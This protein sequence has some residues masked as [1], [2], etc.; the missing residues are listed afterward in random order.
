MKI[1]LSPDEKEK[2][3]RDHR[4]ERNARVCDR[5]KAVLLRSED[6]TCRQIAQALRIHEET[7]RTHLSEWLKDQKL[8]PSNGGSECRLSC[9]QV[10]ALILHLEQNIYTKVTDICAYVLKTWKVRYTISGMTKWLHSHQFRYKQPKAVPAKSDTVLQQ[11]FIEY[12]TLLKESLSDK[13]PIIFI[14]A[15]HPTMATKVTYGWI[16]KGKEQL[17]KQSASRTRENIIGSIELNSLK[18]MTTHPEKVNAETTIEFL[19]KLKTIYPDVSVL[20]IILDQSGYHTSQAV[21]K[22]AQ[23]NNIKL[24][25]LPPYSPNLNPIERLWKFM[26]EQIRNNCFFNSAKEFR[27]TIRDFFRVKIPEMKEA[28]KSRITDNFQIIKNPVP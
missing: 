2:L 21:R 26:N 15:A 22:F 18:V 16:R 12:Y 27:E 11:K 14:D 23:G 1:I 8:K 5:I 3:E 9:D 25:Y 28:L 13:E 10:K 24:H 7:V 19:T 4:H 6:W 20:H 17:I